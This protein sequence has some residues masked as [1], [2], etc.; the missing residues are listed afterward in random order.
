MTTPSTMNNF[1]NDLKDKIKQAKI[2]YDNVLDRTKDEFMVGFNQGYLKA[3]E[4][5][6]TDITGEHPEDNDNG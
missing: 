5:I 2:D 3:L 4:E 1:I 6:F